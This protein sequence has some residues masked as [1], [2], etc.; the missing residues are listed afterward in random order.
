MSPHYS[1][2]MTKTEAMAALTPFLDAVQG[3]SCHECE[4]MLDAA[5]LASRDLAE[6]VGRQDAIIERQ[7]A[8]LTY[9]NALLIHRQA[10]VERLA[11]ENDAL[12]ADLARRRT[13]P[14]ERFYAF[15]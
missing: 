8:K 2:H 11:R 9:A 10:Q 1:Q 5:I 13:M 3:H 15:E 12:R 14:L 7:D 4:A 6:E